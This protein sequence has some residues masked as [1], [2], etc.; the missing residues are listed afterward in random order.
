MTKYVV[1]KVS[2]K[3]ESRELWY[4]SAFRLSP[5]PVTTCS[6]TAKPNDTTSLSPSLRHRTF[7]S[8]CQAIEI[9]GIA[10]VRTTATD[11]L[12]DKIRRRRY[13]IVMMTSFL[14]SAA[15]FEMIIVRVF[16]PVALAFIFNIRPGHNREVDI[17]NLTLNLHCPTFAQV[18][19]YD[20]RHLFTRPRSLIGTPN[21]RHRNEFS[22][23]TLHECGSNS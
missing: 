13:V 1:L 7:I 19:P 9:L 6:Q 12:I 18:L 21:R 4:I 10:L 22:M 16:L 15:K 23:P 8:H 17:V 2:G 5:S 3:F 20:R 11:E 14:E